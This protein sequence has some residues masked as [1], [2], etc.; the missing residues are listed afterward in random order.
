MD[1]GVWGNAALLHEA[2]AV[3]LVYQNAQVDLVDQLGHIDGGLLDLGQTGRQI[4]VEA[5]WS[6]WL[7][8]GGAL[9]VTRLVISTE[10]LGINLLAFKINK[11]L[12]K[13]YI[14]QAT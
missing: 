5:S 2:L 12:E 7:E 4:P 9:R 10:V 1:I 13:K 8:L 11:L 14:I 6:G 3:L